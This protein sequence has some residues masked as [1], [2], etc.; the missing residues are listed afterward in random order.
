MGNSLKF[1]I[2]NPNYSEIFIK[3]SLY[4][5]KM[6]E[7]DYFHEKMRKHILGYTRICQN[8][9]EIKKIKDSKTLI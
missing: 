8:I 1:N 9:L 4:L 6:T 5:Q 2:F 3:I 7:P